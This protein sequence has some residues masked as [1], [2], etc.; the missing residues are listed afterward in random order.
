MPPTTSGALATGAPGVRPEE[1]LAAG[2]A[3]KGRASL[4]ATAIAPRD[5]SVI[6]VSL[7]MAIRA[8]ASIT[9][10]GASAGRTVKRTIRRSG[11]ELTGSRVH[12]ESGSFA[13]NGSSVVGRVC[14][15]RIR[16]VLDHVPCACRKVTA[17]KGVTGSM[18]LEATGVKAAVAVKA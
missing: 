4:L 10:A 15:V 12:Q 14:T 16:A 18:V 2:P 3:G 9:A 11:K 5:N 8:T 13:A 17:T 6:N 7:S 1:T